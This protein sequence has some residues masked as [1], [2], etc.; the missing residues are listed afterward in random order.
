MAV[1][2]MLCRTMPDILT[3]VKKSMKQQG[4]TAY[5]LVQSLKGKRPD[6]KDVPAATIYGFLRGENPINSHD[7]GLIFDVLGWHL[8]PKDAPKRRPEK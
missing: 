3:A 4:I 2:D 6:G 5:R 1:A 7:L 8:P